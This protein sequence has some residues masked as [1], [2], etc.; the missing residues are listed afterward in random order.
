VSSS[1]VRR[2]TRSFYGKEGPPPDDLFTSVDALL[3]NKSER[4]FVEMAKRKG[5]G[6]VIRAGWPDFLLVTREGRTIAVEV[7]GPGDRISRA[8]ARTFAALEHAGVQVYVWVPERPDT[9]T[10]WREALAARGFRR[11]G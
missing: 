7:K 1:A 9:L 4:A 5:H 3:P 8:Q 2:A 11:D 10:P 6:P